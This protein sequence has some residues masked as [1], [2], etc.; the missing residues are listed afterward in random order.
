[1][2]KPAE[3]YKAQSIVT[4]TAATAAVS[5]R[6]EKAATVARNPWDILEA[7]NLKEE[8]VAQLF[9]LLDW[10]GAGAIALPADGAQ[11]GRCARLLGSV[12][13]AGVVVPLLV[14]EARRRPP[15]TALAYPEFRALLMDRLRARVADG[16]LLWPVLI[17]EDLGGAWPG[18]W[19]AAAATAVAAGSEPIVVVA[20]ACPPPVP[21][22]SYAYRARPNTLLPPS[23]LSMPPKQP[24]P[25]PQQQH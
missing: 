19:A 1:V 8:W 25:P 5:S 4:V 23:P 3:K 15:G 10:G 13:A 17:A 24:P 7:S 16:S 11:A 18:E 6:A 2:E 20:A 21:V 14:E 12:R 9:A 22:R